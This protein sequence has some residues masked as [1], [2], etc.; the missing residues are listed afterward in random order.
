MHISDNPFGCS[1]VPENTQTPENPDNEK[2]YNTAM[3]L[4][5]VGFFVPFLWVAGAIMY[6][7]EEHGEKTR[8]WGKLCLIFAIIQLVA[9][10]FLFGIGALGLGFYVFYMVII[11]F[12]VCCAVAS[13]LTGFR[14][15]STV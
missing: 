11:A 4:F 12:T 7:K 8:M 2:D 15:I 5:V 3:L 6:R 9:T 1:H 10:V 14:N 13:D